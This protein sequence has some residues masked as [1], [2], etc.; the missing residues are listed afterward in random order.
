MTTAEVTT[1]RLVYSHTI[2]LSTMDG[3]GFYYPV[4]TLAGSD[5]R[6]Y[7]INRSLEGDIRGV[8]VTIYDIDSEYYGTFASFG[9]GAGQFI[10]PVSITQDGKGH[11]YISD[12]ERNKVTGFDTSG[13]VVNHWGEAGSAPGRLDGPAGLAFDQDNLLYVADQHNHRVQVFSA[14]G[15]LVRHFGSH[16]SGEGQFSLPWGVD[17]GPDGNV[18]VADWQNDR[19]QKLTPDG[20]FITSFGRSGRGDGQLFRPAAVTVDDDGCVYVADWGNERVVIFD[21]DGGLVQNIRGEATDSKWA[22]AFLDINV[23]EAEARAKSDMAPDIEF[24]NDNPHEESSHIEK[25]FW[26]PTSVKLDDEGRL[27]VTESNR[28]RVQIYR[29]NGG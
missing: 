24:F 21:S 26:A 8:R 11:I 14:D 1:Q 29:K 18:Y 25:Y 3:R 12:E 4:D 7:T 17:V 2:G 27:Y 6:L 19:I 20:E 28:H 9:E 23:E 16:G 22:D 10:W 15:E 5:G 13:S